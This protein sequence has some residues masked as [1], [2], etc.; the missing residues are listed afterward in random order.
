M[1]FS[2]SFDVLFALVTAYLFKRGSR[3][4]VFS[5]LCG[6]LSLDEAGKKRYMVDYYYDEDYEYYYDGEA[7]TEHYD[8]SE[9]TPLY[10]T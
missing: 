1:G 10:T 5:C 6:I 9:N 2:I 3:P 4:S 7:D 8:Y